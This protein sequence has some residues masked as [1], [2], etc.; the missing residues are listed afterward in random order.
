[1]VPRILDFINKIPIE[2][3]KFL[4]GVVMSTIITIWNS[5]QNSLDTLY[6]IFGVHLT[7]FILFALALGASKLIIEFVF[8][9]K[10]YFKL[11][12]LKSRILGVMLNYSYLF[13]QESK[14]IS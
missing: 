12:I 13:E 14:V 9:V 6:T 4:W 8:F 1:M 2:T 11:K 3:R 10:G 5:I 7:I